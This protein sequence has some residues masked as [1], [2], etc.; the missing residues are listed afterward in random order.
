MS[1]TQFKQIIVTGNYICHGKYISYQ[2]NVVHI[3]FKQNNEFKLQK[4]FGFAEN[5]FFGVSCYSVLRFL[6][7]VT[8]GKLLRPGKVILELYRFQI[9]IFLHEILSLET[10]F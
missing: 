5:Y 7:P 3:W 2:Y 6:F 9:K 8:L 4:Y 10:Q 1:E